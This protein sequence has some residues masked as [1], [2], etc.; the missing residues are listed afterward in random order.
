MG[1]FD[2]AKPGSYMVM[3]TP[4]GGQ[5]MIRTGVNIGYSDEFRDRETNDHAARIDRQAAGESKASRASCCRRC[6]KCRRTTNRPSKCCS[7]SWRSIRSGAICRR[8]SPARIS[9]RG[10]CWSA[11][12][13]FF[14]DVFV[15]RVQVDF[16]WLAPFWARFAEVVLRRERHEA[17]PETMTRLRSRKAEVDRSLESQRAATRFEPDATIPIDPNAI[18]GRRSETDR[19]PVTATVRRPRQRPKPSSKTNTPRGCFKAKKKVW[20]RPRFESKTKEPRE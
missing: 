9:G 7:R 10:W 8:P 5:A 2:S 17:A 11:S 6:R 12:C 16:R 15:R 19:T 18:A 20:R 4:G 3:V 13:V 1:E 14:A